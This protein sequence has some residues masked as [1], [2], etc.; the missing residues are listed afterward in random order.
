MEDPSCLI[1][2]ALI[3]LCAIIYFIRYQFRKFIENRPNRIENKKYRN[4]ALSLKPQIDR[5]K[6][7]DLIDIL[8]L[9]NNQYQDLMKILDK[10][11]NFIN[12]S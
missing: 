10:K 11:Y 8:Q 7:N 1:I 5:I 3:V 4:I 9:M 6:I 2:I 12:K